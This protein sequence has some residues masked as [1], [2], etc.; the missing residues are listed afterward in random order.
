MARSSKNK[1]VPAKA[2]VKVFTEMGKW[3][4]FEIKGLKEGTVL[5]GIFNPINK[6][7]DFKWKGEDAMLWIGANAELV[8][9][10]KPVSN[11]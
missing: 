5:S 9:I 3:C 7:F 10:Q 11:K 4:L 2:R 6:A 1:P 8:E